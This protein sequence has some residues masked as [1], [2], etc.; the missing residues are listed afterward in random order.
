MATTRTTRTA[1]D[2][3]EEAAAIVGA[4]LIEA[5]STNCAAI[6]EQAE[7]QRALLVRLLDMLDDEHPRQ[8]VQLR[9]LAAARL[10][11]WAIVLDIPQEP[12]A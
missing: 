9:T 2:L 8:A 5:H 6:A 1:S 11:R 4:T 7:G 3:I 12:G 10:G